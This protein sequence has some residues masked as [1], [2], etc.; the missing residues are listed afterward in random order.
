MKAPANYAHFLDTQCCQPGIRKL[1]YGLMC[2]LDNCVNYS[3][4]GIPATCLRY[5]YRIHKHW[6]SLLYYINSWH[7]TL[8]Y[9]YCV[10]L[11]VMLDD[12]FIIIWTPYCYVLLVCIWYCWVWNKVIELHWIRH[13]L[14][15]LTNTTPVMIVLCISYNRTPWSCVHFGT[16]Q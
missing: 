15:L 5:T 6:C 12:N 1:L 3:I 4:K 2:R 14:L 10:Q 8:Y 16:P 13:G 11:H 7:N 9:S